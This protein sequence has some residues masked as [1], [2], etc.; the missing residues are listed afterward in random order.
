MCVWMWSFYFCATGANHHFFNLLEVSVPQVCPS[1]KRVNWC[2]CF[3]SISWLSGLKNAMLLNYTSLYELQR[4]TKTS[5]TSFDSFK[6][7]KKLC[8]K[9]HWHILHFLCGACSSYPVI[10][11][12]VKILLAISTG[13]HVWDLT[14][15]SSSIS[16]STLYRCFC[17]YEALCIYNRNDLDFY[18][19]RDNCCYHASDPCL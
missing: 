3:L 18:F 17:V 15:F 6:M 12:V 9:K 11:C 19:L 10:T 5:K 14:S 2:G 1:W 16:T 4:R 7:K 13:T 8:G